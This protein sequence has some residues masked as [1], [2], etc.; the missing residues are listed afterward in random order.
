MAKQHKVLGILSVGKISEETK[1][2][3]VSIY[4]TK[5]Q[6]SIT[7]NLKN[8]FTLFSTTGSQLPSM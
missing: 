1:N 4:V 7:L 8:P 6:N 5:H 2:A 3:S